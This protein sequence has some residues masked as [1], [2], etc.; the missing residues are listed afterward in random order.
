MTQPFIHPNTPPRLVKIF[1]QM[2]F[3]YHQVADRLGINVAHIHNLIT[4]GKEPKDKDIRRALFLPARKQKRRSGDCAHCGKRVN[5]ESNG[6]MFSHVRPDGTYCKG[7]DTRD[8]LM[9]PAVRR[10]IRRMAK[11][12]R[13][14]VLR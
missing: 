10:G 8:F 4:K 7:S 5:L 13:Q 3:K 14:A 12:T 1:K 9:P 11:E 2:D 6:T